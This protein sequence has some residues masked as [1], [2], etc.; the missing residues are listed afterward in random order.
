M[1]F[2]SIKNKIFVEYLTI[3]ISLTI[4][5]SNATYK[6]LVFISKYPKLIWQTFYCI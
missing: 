1:K 5:Y 2:V 6:L 3:T 4:C